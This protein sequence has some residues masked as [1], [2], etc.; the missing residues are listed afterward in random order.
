MSTTVGAFRFLYARSFV[1]RAHV[2]LRRVRSPRYALALLAGALY[3]WVLFARPGAYPGVRTPQGVVP[4]ADGF[5]A[6][7]YEALIILWILVTWLFGGSEPALAFTPAEIQ[8]LFPAPVSR[9]TLVHYKIVQVQIPLL[10]TVLVLMMLRSTTSGAPT[11]LPLALRAI[12]AWVVMM[13]LYLYRVASSLVRMHLAQ[14]GRSKLRRYA[15]PVAIE[16]AAIGVLAWGIVQAWPRIV[17]AWDARSIEGAVRAL[18]EA[19]GAAVVLWPFHA[20]VAPLFART[21]AAWLASI[22]WALVILF[23]MYLWAI[24][25][26]VGFEEAAMLRSE[27]LAAQQA[28]RRLRGASGATKIRSGRSLF[29]LSLS[30]RPW[31]AIVWKNV[32]ALQRM[33]DAR[34]ALVFLAIAVVAV[35]A[36]ASERSSMPAILSG[37]LIAAVVWLALFGAI[38]FRVDLQQDML[39]LSLLRAF[40]VSSAALVGAE[41]ASSVVTICAIQ[42]ILILLAAV[43]VGLALRSMPPTRAAEV[44]SLPPMMLAALIVLPAVTA[45]RVAVANGWAVLLPGWVHL[46]PA[47]NA[48]IEALGQNLLTVVGS[49]LV[50]M[51]LLLLPI[52]AAALVLFVS[53]GAEGS[54]GWF[55][56]PAALAFAAVAAAELWF[57]VHW[58]GGVFART[59][60]SAVEAATA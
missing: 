32:T 16:A 35:G 38:A 26:A 47:R 13:S 45:L 11:S 60:P 21:G 46:G 39:R 1:N 23:A 20:L 12:S 56:V 27:R 4:G 22:G 40:P 10:I 42:G 19:P 54:T 2:Q 52:G 31:V 9:R 30:G 58:L 59:D 29:T 36:N 28:S 14:G 48:G 34:R 24:R 3:Y 41:I 55:A 50:H 5:A 37:L 7:M 43:P 25:S 33:T 15:L 49:L 44:L 6:T 57:L 18:H 51:L 53:R 17:A 8:L